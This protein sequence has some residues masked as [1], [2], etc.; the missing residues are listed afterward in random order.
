ML[1]IEWG[2]QEFSESEDFILVESRK[3]KKTYK[4]HMR[5]SPVGKKRQLQENLGLENNGGGRN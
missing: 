2:Q 4:K 1:T 5:I 3:K